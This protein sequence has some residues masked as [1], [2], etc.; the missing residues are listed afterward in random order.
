[1]EKYDKRI[2]HFINKTRDITREGVTCVDCFFFGQPCY[3]DNTPD[4]PW[5]AYEFGCD[6]LICE[7]FE[8]RTNCE[9]CDEEYS[10]DREKECECPPDAN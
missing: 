5:D 7:L 8:Y 3:P 4:I 9:F 6:E 2:V 10:A 1:M